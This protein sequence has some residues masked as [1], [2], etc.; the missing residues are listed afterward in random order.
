MSSTPHLVSV[1]VGKPKPL[2]QWRGQTIGSG[3]VKTPVEGRVAVRGVNLDGDAQADWRVHG[4][5]DKAV[6]AY[7]REDGD[8][9]AAEL[10]R[11]IPPGMFGENLTTVGVDCSGAVIGERWRIGTVELEVC[12]PRM[13]C[14]KLGMRF[15]DGKMLRRFAQA[16]R[17]GVYFRIVT[18]GELGVGDDIEIVD[19][20]DHGITIAQ[21]SDAFLLDRSLL[22]RVLEAPQLAEALREMVAA[23]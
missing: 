5:P 7:A 21:V 4:G 13:P 3:I 10:D 18:E 6:Y 8:W 17:P 20:P 15:G 11:E 22:P 16:S 12:Q 14:F 2:G 23:A 19:R 9:W 1:N